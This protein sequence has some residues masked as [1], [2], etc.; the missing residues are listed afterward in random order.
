MVF[1]VDREEEEEEEE[2]IAQDGF[3]VD[4]EVFTDDTLVFV[5]E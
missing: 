3:G 4:G 2:G 1:A 5:W